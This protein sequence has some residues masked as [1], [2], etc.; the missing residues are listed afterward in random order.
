[1]S[2]WVLVGFV[3]AEPRR[4]LPLS[5]SFFLHIPTNPHC[6]ERSPACFVRPIPKGQFRSLRLSAFDGSEVRFQRAVQMH[7][8]AGRVSSRRYPLKVSAALTQC[9]AST[10]IG[11]ILVCEGHFSSS[12]LFAGSF[13][14]LEPLP[15]GDATPGSALICI[16]LVTSRAKGVSTNALSTYKCV[17]F[18]F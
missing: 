18:L 7:V 2:S 10:G 1:M 15:M 12:C 8:P 9:P 4:D 11:Q 5:S 3:T 6:D 13:Y 14:H 16:C 17:S